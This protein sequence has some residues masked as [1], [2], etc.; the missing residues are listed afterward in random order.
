[1]VGT[2]DEALAPPLTCCLKA[3]KRS[4]SLDDCRVFASLKV[5]AFGFLLAVSLLADESSL[6]RVGDLKLDLSFAAGIDA[7][8]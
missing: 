3:L 7:S 1:M 8:S 4:K 5:F 6:G 2:L